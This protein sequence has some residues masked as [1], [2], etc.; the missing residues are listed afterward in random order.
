MMVPSQVG[1]AS[2]WEQFVVD[3]HRRQRPGVGWQA[4]DHRGRVGQPTLGQAENSL[5]TRAVV[6]H[7]EKTARSR[8]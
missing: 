4:C 7:L 8:S 5:L 1:R 3:G 6:T 2:A